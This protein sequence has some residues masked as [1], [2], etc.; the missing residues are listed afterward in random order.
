MSRSR[1]IGRRRLC[2]FALALTLVQPMAALAQANEGEKRRLE[3]E[4]DRQRRKKREERRDKAMELERRHESERILR[5]E[6]RREEWRREREKLGQ[7]R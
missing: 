2:A 4:S 7:K 3:R 6:R 5:E 1:P